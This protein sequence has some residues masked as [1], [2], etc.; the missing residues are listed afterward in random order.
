MN[1]IATSLPAACHNEGLVAAPLEVS[2]IA[3]QFG[4]IEDVKRMIERG[5]N[6]KML[7]DIPFSEIEFIKE[8]IGIGEKI[9]HQGDYRGVYFC[10]LDKKMCLYGINLDIK[11]LTLSEPIAMLHTDDHTR[12]I[13]NTYLRNAV[14]TGDSCRTA[15]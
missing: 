7:T 11:R 13:L 5:V 10:T 2:A 1:S 6:F 3:S 12:R 15:S 4:I 9:R 14:A 8:A